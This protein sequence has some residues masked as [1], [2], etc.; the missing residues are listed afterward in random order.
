MSFLEL[1]ALAIFLGVALVVIETGVRIALNLKPPAQPMELHMSFADPYLALR[2]VSDRIAELGGSV[3]G[4][5]EAGSFVVG[6]G[7]ATIEGTYELARLDT[8][9]VSI[10]QRPVRITA[11][12]IEKA[13]RSY[14]EQPPCMPS[15]SGA[16]PSAL[17]RKE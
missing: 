2:R 13:I 11:A 12:M 1:V 6:H 9:R 14:A 7:R 15:V 10:D 5:V 17:P 16:G 4:N 3:Q 8:Y